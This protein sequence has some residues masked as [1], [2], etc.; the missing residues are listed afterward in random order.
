[1]G[2]TRH[3]TQDSYKSRLSVLARTHVPI[4]IRR[5]IL[6][7]TRWEETL[8][9]APARLLHQPRR[10]SALE[11]AVRKVA[12]DRVVTFVTPILAPGRP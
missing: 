5:I 8:G 11:R 7:G 12:C 1:M 10:R 3:S 2:A 4:S 9:A 6:K